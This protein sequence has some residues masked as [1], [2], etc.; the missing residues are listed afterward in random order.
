MSE[1]KLIYGDCLEVMKTMPDN[2]VGLIV[3]DPPYCVGTTSSGVKGDWTDNNLIL[4]FFE[5]FFSETRRILKDGKQFYINTDWRT[6][7]LIFPIAIQFLTVKNCIV[8]D[9]EWI[10]AGSHYR[11]SHEFIMY[12]FKGDNKRSF[13][14]AERD[15]WRISP[16]NFTNKNKNHQSE[17]PVELINKML[18]NSS[19][20]NDLVLDCFMGSGTTGIACCN[21]NRDFV[22]IEINKKYFQIAK[23]R[24]EDAQ[25]QQRLFV[26][27]QKQSMQLRIPGGPSM[28]D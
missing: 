18:I 12:G 15:V 16:I 10:K 14:A 26:P 27:E 9:Y 8:W 5:R 22:G 21:L 4:P 7:P 19:N 25:R 17:K 2:S 24:I 20:E 11:F 13:S 28:P 6:W 1:F 3:T 23:K